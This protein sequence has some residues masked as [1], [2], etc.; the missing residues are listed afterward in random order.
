MVSFSFDCLDKEFVGFCVTKI[1]VTVGEGPLWGVVS[2]SFD[3]LD[4]VFV[5]FSAAKFM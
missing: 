1:H 4:K 2:F 5:G 3:C